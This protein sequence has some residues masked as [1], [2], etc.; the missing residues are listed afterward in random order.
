MKQPLENH[1]YVAA[2]FLFG[3]SVTDRKAWTLHAAET[4]I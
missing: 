2:P 4:M 1:R 3:F